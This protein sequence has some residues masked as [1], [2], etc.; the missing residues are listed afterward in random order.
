MTK[1]GTLDQV[2][3]RS[4]EVA[5]EATPSENA[6]PMEFVL[7]ESH[8][9][10]PE[11]KAAAATLRLIGRGL[12]E[13]KAH[14]TVL[15][16]KPG[17]P[18]AGILNPPYIG[19]YKGV[20]FEFTCGTATR[21]PR[22][23]TR[24]RDSLRGFVILLLR[25]IQK[26][27]ARGRKGLCVYLYGEAPSLCLPVLLLSK[28]LRF[29][30]IVELCEWKPAFKS[31]NPLS[32]WYHMLRVKLADGVLAI[33]EDLERKAV[34]I[35]PPPRKRNVLLHSIL[36]DANEAAVEKLQLEIIKGPYV[37][38][39]GDFGGYFDSVTWLIRC[40]AIAF[41]RVEGLK[42][43]LVGSLTDSLR[44]RLLGE[45]RAA[46]LPEDRV[47]PTGYVSRQELWTLYA[48]AVALLAPLDSSERSRARFPWKIAEYLAA[49]RPVITNGVGEIPRYFTDGENAL[50]AR[51]DDEEDFASKIEL[52]AKNRPLADRIGAAGRE[53]A[54]RQFHYAAFGET[55]VRFVNG[56][57]T[58][59][60]TNSPGKDL[61]ETPLRATPTEFPR[62]RKMRASRS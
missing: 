21:S 61:L 23:L 18:L 16:P 24:R 6:A 25:I 13:A 32:N 39:C 38:W 44:L 35:L 3:R 57:S 9:G 22:F 54:L 29:P 19:L 47:I 5:T 26:R 11:G 8:D 20:Q 62:A 52:V 2:I 15:L 56:L 50:V 34:A 60:Y 49:G 7:L 27:M 31:A 36:V 17:G 45:I 14:V 12:V 55:L 48:G 33:S 59:G 4:S 58:P 51:P 37:L 28:L 10:F 53:L 41:K 43:V 46:G 30:V 1:T 40:C 42:L